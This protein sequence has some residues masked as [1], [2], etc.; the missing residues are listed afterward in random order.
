MALCLRGLVVLAC[1]AALHGQSGASQPE[2]RTANLEPD[3]DIGV[4][5]GEMG[6]H[7]GRMLAT[8]DKMNPNA[9]VE[10]G[11]SET[12]AEQLDSCKAQTKAF[13]DEAI[14]LAS[15]PQNL[16]AALQLLYRIE[17][18]DT[19]LLSLEDGIRKYQSPADA[20]ALAAQAAENGINLSRFRQYL[21]DLA[22]EREQRYSVMDKEAQRC[23]AFLFDQPA[24][25]PASGRKK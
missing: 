1:A 19:M 25:S 22:A 10:K 11:A 17:G 8:L 18:A 7:A 2:Q 13:H 23:R 24:A 20:Q 21:V 12:Y 4:V 5:L 14:A 6:A 9:W 15:N 3:W 16:P